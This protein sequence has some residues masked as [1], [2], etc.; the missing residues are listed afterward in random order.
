MSSLPPSLDD[1][2]RTNH[3]R[4]PE[5][6]VFEWTDR[7]GIPHSPGAIGVTQ[8]TSN[9]FVSQARKSSHQYP[10][11]DLMAEAIWNYQVTYTYFDPSNFIQK[12]F[13]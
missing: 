3:T 5:K 13:F 4:H 11:A 12:Y 6:N 10:F 7:E 2:V 1:R 8:Y 9:F